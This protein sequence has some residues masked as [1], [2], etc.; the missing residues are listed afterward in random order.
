LSFYLLGRIGFIRRFVLGRNRRKSAL[1]A[2]LA[3]ALVAA[4]RSPG[5]LLAQEAVPPV[6]EAA[7]PASE[8]EA[9]AP[10]AAEGE[11][12]EPAASPAP[13]EDTDEK[14]ITMD[15]QDVDLSVL[16]KFISEITARNFIVDERVKGKVTIISP[17]KISVDEAYTVFQSVLQV[18][19]FTTVPSGAIIKILPAQEAKSAT[20]P[21]MFPGGW[22]SPSDEF[23]T[24]LMPLTNVDANNMVPIIQPL[25]SPNGL[26]AAYAPTNSLIIIDSAANIERIANI[27]HELD[28]A[29]F[30]RGVEVIRLNYAFA[31]ELAATL[32]QVLEDTGDGGPVAPTAAAET[33]AR[34]AARAARAAAAAQPAAAVGQTTTVTGGGTGERAFKIIPDER[35]NALIV[36]AGPLEM[37]RIKDLIVKLDVPLPLGTGRIH[38][39]A[40]KYANAFEIVPVLADLIGGTGGVGGLSGGLLNRALSGSSA[41]RGGRLGQR[42]GFGA[43][44]GGL[45]T[46]GLG[47]FGAGGL[48]GGFGALRSGFGGRA[49]Q[50]GGATGSLGGFGGGLGAGAAAGGVTSVTGQAGGQFEGEVRITADPSTNSLIVYASPQD[51]ETLKRVIELIDVRRRQVFVEAIILE[52]RVDKVR[53]LGVGYQGGV[54]LDEGVGFG[55]LNF[56]GAQSELNSAIINPA[57]LPGLILAA[58]SN[59]TIRLPDGTVVPADVA[60]LTAAQ[61]DADVNILSAPTLLTTDNQEAEIVVGQNVPFVSSRSTSDVNLANT[62]AT[63]ER[64]DVGITLR[65]TPQISEGGMVRL[66]I[67]Q[68]VSALIPTSVAGLDPN[69]VGPSTTIRS[70]TTTVVARNGQTVVIGGL[71]SDDMSNTQNKV[72]F[73]SEIPI[74]G[75]LL[76]GRSAERRKVN[77][78]IFLTPHII[79]NARE[80]RALSLAERDKVKAMLEENEFPNKRRQQLER[81]SWNPDLPPEDEDEGEERNGQRESKR[82]SNGD[83]YWESAAVEDIP[84]VNRYV[85]LAA[86]AT[87][88][89]PPPGLESESGLIAVKLPEESSLE[90][91]FRKGGRYRFHSD[92]F[93]ALYQCLEAFPSAQQALLVYP[94]GLPVDRETGEILH[95]REWQDASSSN[96]AAWTALN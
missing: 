64:R 36:V 56:G 39:Y 82:E 58:A 70:A 84:Q 2:I 29:G 51:F 49:Q 83:P 95:W 16:V 24:R 63:V 41:F 12:A 55:R 37:R 42:G 66:D 44:A 80:H 78:L 43:L 61:N 94:E 59:Q 6:P 25:V 81:P 19:G 30:E 93:E 5:V 67:F 17:A 20:V 86:F 9:S 68:E 73:F 57:S 11:P 28:V 15:F 26:L 71:I 40:L 48:R 89:A 50:L 21:T 72:P 45:G 13:A 60:L 76:T 65:I 54:G 14:K 87:R 69:L 38:V 91:M 4:L 8:A 46:E 23:I 35:T 7:P 62:F 10:T 75:N 77:L 79:R 27:I 96:A 32:A 1:A 88:G 33:A 52:L 85:L 92:A 18:K 34:R 74:V 90:R 31:T 22:I 53:A 3:T 47:G